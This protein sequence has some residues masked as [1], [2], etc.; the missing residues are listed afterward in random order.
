M[1]RHRASRALLSLHRGVTVLSSTLT[2]PRGS[3]RSSPLAGD[4]PAPSHPL[5][6]LPRVRGEKPF[7]GWA[8][9]ATACPLGSVRAG[10]PG[11]R[12]SGSPALPRRAVRGLAQLPFLWQ[13]FQ[14]T[15]SCHFRVQHPL[16]CS[17]GEAGRVGRCTWSFDL[18]VAHEQ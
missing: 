3:A 15:L 4:A 14:A 6:L 11:A 1:V 2:F 7:C 5:I 8:F 16:L 13:P 18:A 10:R 17:E 12:L 9:R